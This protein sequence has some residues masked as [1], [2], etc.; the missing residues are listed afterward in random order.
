MS[1]PVRVHRVPKGTM[2][3]RWSPV[4]GEPRSWTKSQPPKAGIASSWDSVY[5][6]AR[7]GGRDGMNRRP[8]SSL[9]RSMCK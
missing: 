8:E 5:E 6:S 9:P 3:M 2:P 1:G 7:L 4:Q